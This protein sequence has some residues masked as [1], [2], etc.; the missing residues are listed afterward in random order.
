MEA[1]ATE[2]RKLAADFETAEARKREEERLA[3]AR[4]RSDQM[5]VLI[6]E[7]I[8]GKRWRELLRRAREAAAHGMTEFMLLR[9]PHNLCSD[10]GRS[11]NA[12]VE[13]GNWPETLRGEA[14]ELYLRWKQDLRPHGFRLTARVLD[15]PGGVPGDVGLFLTWGE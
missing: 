3:E 9:F 8:T 2:F 15:F 10:G 1:D 12:L 4:L 7:H 13:N 6:G 14:A 11:I 5:K